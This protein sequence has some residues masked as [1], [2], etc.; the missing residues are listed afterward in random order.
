MIVIPLTQADEGLRL[1]AVLSALYPSVS[2]ATVKRLIDQ[3]IALRSDGKKCIKGEK[4]TLTYT[5]HLLEEPKVEVLEANPN[6]QVTV[7]YEDDDL[8]AINKP[9]GLNCQPNKLSEIDTIANGLLARWPTLKGVGDTPL[10]CGI[11]HRIDFDTSGLVLVAKNQEIYLAL[12]EQ[13]AARR[14][15]KHYQA[16]VTGTVVHAQTIET[17]LAHNPRYPGRMVDASKWHDVKRPMKA[18]TSFKPNLH[19][20]LQGYPVS[21]L[22]V[23]IFTGVTHQIRAQLSF[24]GHPIVGDKTYGG[25]QLE[26]FNR[27]FLHARRVVF[28][29]PRTQQMITIEA[30]LT[31]DLNVLFSK[32]KQNIRLTNK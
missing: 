24:N 14:V 11:L 32:V 2:R 15:E 19:G 18:V 21:L 31:K 6:L 29:H 13:F 8:I 30:P 5:Y 7:L 10:T 1:D 3:G 17:Y 22:D 28:T 12:R 4:I 26:N 25:L 20:I 9:A 16:L 23:T 27:H